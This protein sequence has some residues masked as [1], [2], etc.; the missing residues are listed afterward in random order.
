MFYEA[1]I[2]KWPSKESK[3]KTF[4]KRKQ[5]ISLIILGGAGLSYWSFPLSDDSEG[6]EV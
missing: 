5:T 2:H 3:T 4:L 6:E 1:G